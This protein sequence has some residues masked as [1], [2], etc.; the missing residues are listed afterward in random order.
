MVLLVNIPYIQVKNYLGLIESIVKA[1]YW[2]GEESSFG[3]IMIIKRK[4]LKDSKN[5]VVLANIEYMVTDKK[6][7]DNF[8]KQLEQFSIE[9]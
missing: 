2:T 8:S 3:V 7:K 6:L 9:K 5:K 1:R 4:F